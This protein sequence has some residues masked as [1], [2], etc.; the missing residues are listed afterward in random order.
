MDVELI[1]MRLATYDLDVGET[2]GC[3]V[4]VGDNPKETES[5]AFCEILDRCRIAVGSAA[6]PNVGEKHPRGAL[7]FLES[8]KF[9][10]ASFSDAVTVGQHGRRDS[11]V[12][13][14]ES[15]SV[16]RSSSVAQGLKAKCA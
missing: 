14:G 6:E 2:D 10:R 8:F 15:I 7:D 1:E 3:I 16:L 13:I 11:T 12:P 9:R 5:F 4:V